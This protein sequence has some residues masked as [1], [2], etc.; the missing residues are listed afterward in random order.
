MIISYN[1][2]QRLRVLWIG[3]AIVGPLVMLESCRP[4]DDGW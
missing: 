1:L 2:Y 4:P 3:L